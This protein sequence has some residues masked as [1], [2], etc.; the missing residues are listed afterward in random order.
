MGGK[1]RPTARGPD[2]KAGRIRA[3]RSL[4]SVGHR[5]GTNSS[6]LC[7]ASPSAFSTVH[8]PFLT[9]KVWNLPISSVPEPNNRRIVELIPSISSAPGRLSRSEL[10]EGSAMIPTWLATSSKAEARF[11]ERPSIA[12][13]EAPSAASL[14]GSA[15]DSAPADWPLPTRQGH[16]AHSAASQRTGR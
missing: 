14:I 7:R 12:R 2:T 1:G 3:P 5:Q 16:S 8:E 4:S 10:L 6:T 15:E 11:P 9:P 13:G